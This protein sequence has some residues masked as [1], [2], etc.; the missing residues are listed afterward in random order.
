MI[1]EG[2]EISLYAMPCSI[3]LVVVYLVGHEKVK[4]IRY[5]G[6]KQRILKR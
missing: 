5:P 4:F 3:V 1:G 6:G 2:F